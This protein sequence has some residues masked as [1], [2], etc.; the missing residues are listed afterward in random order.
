MGKIELSVI[1]PLYNEENVELFYLSLTQALESIGL[2]YEVILVDD[3]SN[4][5]IA[6]SYDALAH[7]D[8]HVKIIRHT[9]NLGK[10]AAILSGFSACRAEKVLVLDGDI[11][12]KAVD[13]QRF[14]SMLDQGFDVLFGNRKAW[15][16]PFSRRV[17]SACL[18]LLVS[19]V[20]LRR[21][22]DV[23]TGFCFFSR[24]LFSNVIDHQEKTNT[25]YYPI[26]YFNFF[27]GG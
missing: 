2:D 7:K 24:K 25:P 1:S 16:R 26:N 4:R 11:E 17:L 22:R 8:S 15:H 14:C 9:G 19:L 20:A 27:P 13:I 12:V 18:N 3:G 6:S 21:I 5:E 10:Q 23:G